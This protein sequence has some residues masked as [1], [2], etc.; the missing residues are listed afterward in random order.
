MIILKKEE[1]KN[2]KKSFEM[3]EALSRSELHFIR[4]GEEQNTEKSGGQ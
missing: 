4:G 1:S 2:E 3:L